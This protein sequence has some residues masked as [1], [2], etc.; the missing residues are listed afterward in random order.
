MGGRTDFVSRH[1]RD[2]VCRRSLLPRRRQRHDNVSVF[3]L[4]DNIGLSGHVRWRVRVLPEFGCQ[5]V[6]KGLSR[7]S[8]SDRRQKLSNTNF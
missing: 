5:Y 7:S 1:D 4:S 8:H 2:L 3:P 6:S